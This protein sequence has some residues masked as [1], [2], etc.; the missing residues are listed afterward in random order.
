M[1]E[2]AVSA[3]AAR[4]RLARQAARRR[5]AVTALRV[6]EAVCADAASALGNG[7][8]PT[9]AREVAWATAV[10]LVEVAEAL[11]RTIRPTRFERQWMAQQWAG[12]GLLSKRQI[13]DRLG[14]SER[15][16]HRYLGHP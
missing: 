1:P 15:T 2:P 6:G 7:A 5:E 4:M 16:V 3:D 12:R 14:V 8:G 9:E 13:A 10:E 11:R